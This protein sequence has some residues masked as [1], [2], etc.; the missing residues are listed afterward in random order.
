MA[1]VIADDTVTANDSLAIYFDT[2]NNRGDP[3]APDRFFQFT[4]QPAGA[5]G[6]GIGTNSDSDFWESGYTS[7]E[8]EY[9]YEL[10]PT[11]W[12]IKMRINTDTEMAAL[13]GMFNMMAKVVFAG[14]D[15]ASWP[16]TANSGD[17]STWQGVINVTCP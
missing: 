5:I 10:N 13:G 1:V 6:R 15:I 14:E 2:D 16:Q 7:N 4:R 3:S 11:N 8:W 17:L 9:Q 12:I